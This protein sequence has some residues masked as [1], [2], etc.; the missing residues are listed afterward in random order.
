MNEL[1]KKPHEQ[2]RCKHN[3]TIQTQTRTWT[4]VFE[5]DFKKTIDFKSFKLL[6]S[7]NTNY[8]KS[9]KECKNS[10]KDRQALVSFQSIESCYESRD[11]HSTLRHGEL[12]H[13][14]QP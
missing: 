4:I 14:L 9:Q 6:R 11:E 5:Q 1:F 10:R 12:N 3:Q 8:M 13:Y 2:V 7:S